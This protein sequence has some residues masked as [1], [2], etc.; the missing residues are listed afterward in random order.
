MVFALY[1]LLFLILI[2]TLILPIKSGPSGIP[3]FHLY[4]PMRLRISLY[5]SQSTWSVH[6][7]Y[8][9]GLHTLQGSLVTWIVSLNL[10]NMV[11]LVQVCSFVNYL[12][13]SFFLPIFKCFFYVFQA[14]IL[15]S[16]Q[17]LS[18]LSP[19]LSQAF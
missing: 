2:T 3:C 19:S 12:V 13:V 11:A 15:F 9:G 6:K 8:P 7:S 10:S 1:L 5:H 16:N 4:F 18:I 14:L 17:N